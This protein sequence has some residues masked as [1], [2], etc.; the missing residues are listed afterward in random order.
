MNRITYLTDELITD[1]QIQSGKGFDA[2]DDMVTIEND[3][4]SVSNIDDKKYVLF[5]YS[6]DK[7]Q[8]DSVI[9]FI[10]PL[11]KQIS[12]R[13]WNGIKSLGYREFLVNYLFADSL[14]LLNLRNFGKKSVA[15][16][17]VVKP[18]I[19]DFIKELYN[20]FNT[21]S[22]DDALK[23]ETIK[24]KPLKER[25]GE[26]QYRVI[27]GFLEKHLKSASVR[28]RNAIKSYGND[29]IEDFV[30]KNNDIK[31][32]KNIGRK[33]ESEI[34]LIITNIR[35]Y[36][37]TLEN[38]A[39]YE[40]ELFIIKKNALYGEHFD[41]YANSFYSKNGHLPML[42]ILNSIL[43]EFLKNNRNFQIFNL[44][45]PIFE[46]EDCH[47]LERIAEM[48]NL[49][50]E[51]VRQ[52]Y[53]KVR[54]DLIEIDSSN[55]K[56]SFYSISKFIVGNNDWSYITDEFQFNNYI[57]LSMVTN[58]YFQENHKLTDDFILFLIGTLFRENFIPIGKPILPY[59]TRS[60][61]EWT[62]CYLVK[63]EL[64]DKFDF[65]RFLDLVK[66]YENSN[67]DD[68]K[69]SVRELIIDTFFEA[70]IS[71]DSSAVEEISEVVSSILIQEVGI[72][73]DD[74]FKFTIEGKKEDDVSDAIYNILKLNGNPISCDD[75]HLSINS[76]YPHK[77]KSTV[78]LK[79]LINRDIRM[80]FVGSNNLVALIEWEHI[81]LGSIRNIIIQYLEQSEEPQK[82]KEIVSY[83]QKHRDT[84]DNSVRATMG[85]GDQFVQFSGGY[86]GLSWKQYP[87]VYYLDESD[88]AFYM[89][90]QELEQFLQIHKH[91]P[92]FSSDP[93]EQELHEWW[94]QSNS[95]VKLSKYQK[96]EVKRIVTQ[97]KYFARKKKHLRWF[98]NCRRYYEFVQENHRRPSNSSPS[99]QE[100]CQWLQK[101]SKDFANGTLTQQQE[102]CYLDLCKSL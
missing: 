62:N 75:L 50:R 93:H 13:A 95:Y 23:Q 25:L 87:E 60:K 44:R 73:P 27:T 79:S 63:K 55:N 71:Y 24:K 37:A 49:T 6:L 72:I 84:S 11:L 58:K 51:R 96:S 70:W 56:S 28:S 41:E 101:A 97:Y 90:I 54:K 8:L 33:S 68:L 77:F 82:V 1:S 92:F 2:V 91:F 98:D 35:D 7:E 81:K 67:T 66:E 69:A 64:T 80:C 31:T 30:N 99:E 47:T 65:T 39:L 5:L 10:I 74:D 21:D 76:M 42:H 4:V 32:I 57:D 59:P 94:I 9:D 100:L 12:I 46:N 29:F 89:R 52:I 34:A 48:L 38:K 26:T 102:L 3:S 36:V 83:V 85:S 40:E 16:F 86:Y 88:R 45:E 14:K 22:V 43:N 61:D 18:A 78:S 15:D 53:M 20:G 19:I 17:N